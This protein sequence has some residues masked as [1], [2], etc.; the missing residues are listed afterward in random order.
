MFNIV[1]KKI[2]L[3]LT[4][5]LA[6][7]V[8]YAQP[9]SLIFKSGTYMVG[10]VKTMD[11]GVVTVETPYSDSDF[12]IEWD[13]ISE[14]YTKTYFLITLSN[15]SRYNGTLG[16]SEPERIIIYTDDGKQIETIFEDIVFLDDRDKGFWSQLYFSFDV[17][18]DLTKANNFR[19]FSVRSN[20]GYTAKRWN[21]DGT[22]NTLYSSQNETEDI[23][24]SDGGFSYKYF[25]PK[26]WYPL[27]SIDF[28]SS[29]EQQ[30]QL[31]T[32]GKLGMGK[33]VIH[34]NRTY[35]GF[36]GG[37]NYNNEN[38]LD[39]TPDR[40]SWEGFFGTELNLFDIGDLNLFTKLLAYPS[41]TESGRWRADF[42][43]DARYEMPFDDDFYLK[44]GLTFN[45][46]NRPVEGATDIDYVIHTG[47]GWSW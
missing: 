5:L 40:Q 8:I 16:M 19:Q 29:S 35:W 27:V 33:Y 32:T 30:L 45:Y 47:F 2:T 44:L 41:F 3:I 43:F 1:M 20:L 9:D 42:S 15:G 46:D 37:A 7:V 18:L 4:L 22:Y 12:K 10:E 31:R 17:G 21:L 28:L 11:R 23:N 25:L 14:I 36:S 39:D 34:T 26:D 6:T 24:R 13:G 38:F